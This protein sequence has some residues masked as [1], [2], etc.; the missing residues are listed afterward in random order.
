[1]S[2]FLVQ[3]LFSVPTLMLLNHAMTLKRDITFIAAT[4]GAATA[5]G[6]V[7]FGKVLLDELLMESKPEAAA[8]NENQDGAVVACQTV[9]MA[10][11][12]GLTS[13]SYFEPGVTAFRSTYVVCYVFPLYLGLGMVGAQNIKRICVTEL[14]FRATITASLLFE[15]HA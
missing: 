12:F 3:Y 14:L 9:L 15:L 4:M 11:F 8:G 7:T 13:L 10:L 5:Y 6:L 2:T 1:M